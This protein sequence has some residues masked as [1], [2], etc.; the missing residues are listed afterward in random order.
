MSDSLKG[1]PVI[2]IGTRS[3]TPASSTWRLPLSR[4]KIH[5]PSS[6]LADSTLLELTANDAEWFSCEMHLNAS[7]PQR[8]FDNQV[9]NDGSNLVSTLSSKSLD[10]EKTRDSLWQGLLYYAELVFDQIENC[11]RNLS[12]GDVLVRPPHG[13]HRQTESLKPMAWPILEERP[14]IA[15][16]GA[17]RFPVA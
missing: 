12:T 1:N 16:N 5:G 3:C 15:S 9:F 2:H 13:I 14:G 4:P 11:Q 8:F 7:P 6:N 17:A 10:P